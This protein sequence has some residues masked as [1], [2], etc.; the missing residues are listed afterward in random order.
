MAGRRVS[1][2]SRDAPGARTVSTDRRVSAGGRDLWD[3]LATSFPRGRLDPSRRH[4]S[5]WIAQ[6]QRTPLPGAPRQSMLLVKF[7]R[8]TFSRLQHLRCGVFDTG[9]V[10][11]RGMTDGIGIFLGDRAASIGRRHTAHGM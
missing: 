9:L 7:V 10:A 2:G 5:V 3:L 4:F 6:H 11:Q 1:H 8:A